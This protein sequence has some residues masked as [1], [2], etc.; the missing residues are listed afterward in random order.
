MRSVYYM[1]S[2]FLTTILLVNT[3]NDTWWIFDSYDH[4]ELFNPKNPFH[5]KFLSDKEIC[6]FAP[7]GSCN[8]VNSELESSPPFDNKCCKINIK[9]SYGCYT[10]FSGKYHNTN[11]YS[12]D[13]S[14]EGFSYDCDGKGNKY[15][16]SSKFSPTEKW[17][18]TIKEKLDCIYSKTEDT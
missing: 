5:D 14:N 12:L 2:I 10:I 11:L 6:M 13:K 1:L 7:L 8:S 15:F 18:I 9:S 3:L 16:D 4:D 17:E